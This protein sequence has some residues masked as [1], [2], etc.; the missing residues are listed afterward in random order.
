MKRLYAVLF[1]LIAI[2]TVASAQENMY[3][4]KDGAVI[5]SYRI[6]DVDYITF[7]K[8]AKE[9][10][11]RVSGTYTSA[12][13]SQSFDA[14]LVCYADGSY[15]IEAPFGVAGYTLDFTLDDDNKIVFTN[16]YSYSGGYYNI[17]VSSEYYISAYTAGTYSSFEEG[18][19]K[20][21]GD[22]WF[23][24]YLYSMDGTQVGS[25]GYD[26]FKWGSTATE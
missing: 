6:A 22:L 9:E 8:P 18:S 1:A 26:E 20:D 23:C 10:A 12:Q 24:T 2:V 21:S 14:Q 7:T 15:S 17:V 25:Y 19:G 3:L 4:I 13:L 16:Q 5:K 11:W